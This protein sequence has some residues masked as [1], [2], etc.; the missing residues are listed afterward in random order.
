MIEK[1]NRTTTIGEIVAAFPQSSDFFKHFKIDFCCGGK[2]TLEQA[3]A[4]RKLP[5]DEIVKKLEQFYLENNRS[6]DETDWRMVESEK[7]L[8]HIISVHHHFALSEV[9]QMTPY[10][11]KVALVHGKHH[12]HLH[13]LLALFTELKEELYEHFEKEETAVFPKILKYEKEKSEQSRIELQILINS[14]EDE[15]NAAGKILKKIR[16][17]TND[18]HVPESACG[19]YRLVYN[20]LEMLEDDMFQHIHLENNI[21][22]PRY[23]S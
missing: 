20:R 11:K 13:Q 12:P 5:A 15:H 14:L 2:K 18:Y 16:M 23:L 8:H 22:F 19:T 10:V 21:L 9:K 4:D 6:T 1:F 7:L 17:L 3:I